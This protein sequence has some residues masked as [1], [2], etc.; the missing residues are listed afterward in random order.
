MNSNLTLPCPWS[1]PEHFMTYNPDRKL[2][3]STPVA[4]SDV[5]ACD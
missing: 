4:M 1:W 3:I 2:R 5:L